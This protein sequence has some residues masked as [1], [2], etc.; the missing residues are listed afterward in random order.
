[1]RAETI[2]VYFNDDGD[3]NAVRNA[4]ALRNRIA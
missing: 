2:L 3:G 1:V 4:A